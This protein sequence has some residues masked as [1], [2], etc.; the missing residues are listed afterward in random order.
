[1]RPPLA[2]SAAEPRREVG[3][4]DGSAVIEASDV[5]APIGDAEAVAG[6]LMSVGAPTAADAEGLKICEVAEAVVSSPSEMGLNRR[7]RPAS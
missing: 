5:P 7:G 6:G 2:P 3:A 1:V 4:T